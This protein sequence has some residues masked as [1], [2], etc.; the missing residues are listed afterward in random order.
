MSTKLSMSTDK[1]NM[2]KLTQKMQLK[3]IESLW[4]LLMERINGKITEYE[5]ICYI[6][7]CSITESTP[8]K[9]ECCGI[10]LHYECLKEY[11][12]S[13]ISKKGEKI[14]LQQLSCLLCKNEMK[15]ERAKEIFKPINELSKKIKKIALDQLEIDKR[16][17]DDEVENKDG[18]FYNKPDEYAMKLYSI[19]ICYDC[20]KPY[21]GGENECNVDDQEEENKID[22]SER[23]CLKCAKPQT[24]ATT[25]D[26]H[27]AE[28][29]QW[30]CQFCC[31]M[32]T[33]YCWGTTHFCESCHR[34]A[35]TLRRKEKKDLIQ[36][37]C[38][39]SSKTNFPEKVEGPC[40]LEQKHPP[41]GEE[42]CLG[43]AMCRQ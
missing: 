34:K 1:C 27:G 12:K 16:T 38:K 20:N 26:K 15:H 35:W 24:F 4:K 14:T 2:F 13:G 22:P 8:I 6:C 11:I 41:H 39:S 31:S 29:I 42:Y 33:Y 32:A 28:Y 37:P 3:H 25:C 23:L 17:N 9:L 10:S 7:Y 36:C 18:E 40:P 21:F 43:C 5:D 19:Y 30:K